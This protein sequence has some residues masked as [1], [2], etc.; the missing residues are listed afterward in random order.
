MK[1]VFD[2]GSEYLAVTSSMCDDRT[3]PAEFKF[4]K[5]DPNK[6]S[7]VAR[8]KNETQSRCLTEGYHMAQS[9]SAKI[10]DHNAQ[11]VSY[12]SA[13][14]QGFYYEDFTCLQPIGQGVDPKVKQPSFIQTQMKMK[15]SKC[16]PF[17][18]I[19][20]YQAVGLDKRFDGLLGLSPRKN[21]DKKKQ[22]LL[23][24]LKENGLIDRA[25]V[26][27]SIS[28]TDMKEKPY[29]IFGGFNSTQIIDG[30]KGLKVFKNYKNEL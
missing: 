8:P 5:Y 24:S 4:Q 26:S 17:E 22:H 29:A 11:K 7:M 2:T 6:R 10:L 16:T 13:E 19:A 9:N 30:S 27:F 3:T 28:Q 21:M 15:Y 14:L 23:W 1:L 25:M 20:L 12:G 18:F